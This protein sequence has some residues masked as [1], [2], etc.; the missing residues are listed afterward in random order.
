MDHIPVII[1]ERLRMR[2]WSDADLGEFARMNADPRVMEFMPARL[3]SEESDALAARICG[4]WT[5]HGFGLWA[6]EVRDGA[7]FIGFVG[8]AVPRFDAK[9]TPCVEVGW[10]LA[11]GHWGRGY[12]TEAARAALEF[13]FEQLRLPEIV[14]FTTV[15]NARSRRVMDR[16]GMRH[17][18]ADDFDHPS[19]PPGHLLRPHVVY[20]LS[21][22]DWIREGSRV[23]RNSSCH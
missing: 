12:A 6:I 16:I 3:T 22:P 20:R 8:L 2:G 15:A 7:R 1:T 14:S 21:R 9:F 10:R 4:H 19:I 5:S 23:G 11:A 18:R 13:G 17:D